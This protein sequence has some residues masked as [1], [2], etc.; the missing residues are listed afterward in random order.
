MHIFQIYYPQN[1]QTDLNSQRVY[2]SKNILEEIQEI[3]LCNKKGNKFKSHEEIK[4]IVPVEKFQCL[5]LLRGQVAYFNRKLTLPSFRFLFKNNKLKKFR[6]T[7][8][9]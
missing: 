2:H 8:H 4:I 6:N 5:S 9:F 7:E 3:C 1:L